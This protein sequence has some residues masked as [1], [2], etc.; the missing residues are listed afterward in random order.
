MASLFSY[1]NSKIEPTNILMGLKNTH[2]SSSF[3]IP[4]TI[5]RRA[6]SIVIYISLWIFILYGMKSNKV[7]HSL[8]V[9]IGFFVGLFL[10]F[11]YDFLNHTPDQLV[12][13]AKDKRFTLFNITGQNIL[14]DDKL[15]KLDETRGLVIKSSVFQ[16]YKRENK[17]SSMPIQEFS[18]KEYIK[19]QTGTVATGSPI[20]AYEKSNHLLLSGSYMFIIVITHCILASHHNKKLLSAM[21]PFATTSG[22]LAVAFIGIWFIDRNYTS[23]ITTE[24]IKS[25]IF[26]SAF[27]FALTAI[28]TPFFYV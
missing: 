18:D 19:T 25:K 8:S 24:K 11:L 9:K 28:I 3:W 21:L 22:I 12:I 16:K 13:N 2:R 4:E 14:M 20:V 23:L 26:I 6:M 10:H 7:G 1:S 17:I 15:F 5:E 27:S